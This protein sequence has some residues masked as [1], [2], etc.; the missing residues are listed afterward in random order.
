MHILFTFYFIFIFV[1]IFIIIC[2][3]V[4]TLTSIKYCQKNLIWFNFVLFYIILSFYCSQ[5]INRD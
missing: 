5:M 2:F 4:N 3:C 1:F